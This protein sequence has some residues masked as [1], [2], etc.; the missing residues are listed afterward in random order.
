MSPDLSLDADERLIAESV[1]KFCADRARADTLRAAADSFD[2]A[3]WR[4][5]CAQGFFALGTPEGEGG[6]RQ[7]VACAESL[8]RFVFPGPVVDTFLAVQVFAASERTHVIA[9]EIIVSSGVPP[10]LPFAS[11]AQVHLGL[12]PDRV[13]RLTLGG[14]I[15]ALQSLGGEPWGRACFKEGEDLPQAPRGLFFADVALAAYLTSA[16]QGLLQSTAEYVATRKQFGRAVGSF[17]AVA[18]PLASCHIALSAAQT[19]ARAAAAAFDEEQARA[20]PLATAALA[21]S[22]RAGL[23]AAYTCHQKL[24]A[25]GITSEGPAHPITRRIR[26]LA[27]RVTQRLA[28]EP[29]LVTSFGG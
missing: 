26:Q 17:Q 14:P 28:A 20:R 18:H 3:L 23:D 29:A 5:F 24:G 25:I 11:E 19:L 2:R 22:R 1:A 7:V 15:E 21:S 16:A 10:L 9:G 12:G 6:A 27:A 13:T 4:A 8:G